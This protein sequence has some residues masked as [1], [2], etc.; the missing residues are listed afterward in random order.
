MTVVSA[1]GSRHG[2]PLGKKFREVGRSETRHRV[3][4]TTCIETERATAGV[5]AISDIVES[6]RKVGS[7][8]LWSIARETARVSH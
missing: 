1:H 2:H 3:P 8:D 6:I 4:T 7:I 5:S